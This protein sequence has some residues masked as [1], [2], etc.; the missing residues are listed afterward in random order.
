MHR[1]P[2]AIPQLARRRRPPA[3][4]AA[5]TGDRLAGLT[6]GE[7]GLSALAGPLA[8]LGASALAGLAALGALPVAAGAITP[9]TP[10][11]T[12]LGAVRLA[13]PAPAPAAAPGHGPPSRATLLVPVRY[14]LAMKGRTAG[15]RVTLRAGGTVVGRAR[16]SARLTGGPRRQPDRR[17]QFLF[18]H[19][20]ALGPSAT[21]ALRRHGRVSVHVAAP[22]RLDADGDGR[23]EARW[24]DDATQP[25]RW[26]SAGAFR[27]LTRPGARRRAP[28]CASI[29]LQRIRPRRQATIAVPQCDV[30][31]RWSIA[32][33]PVN[34]RAE[35]TSSQVV[36]RAQV[37]RMPRTPTGRVAR[38][39]TAHAARRVP[40]ARS[41]RTRPQQRRALVYRAPA[42]RAG[43][44]TLT[45][46]A[47][48]PGTDDQALVP[49]DLVVTPTPA[50]APVVRALGDS[51][52]AGFGYYGDGST[53]SLLDLP[54][55]RP[56][57]TAENDACSSNATNTSDDDGPVQYAPDYGLANDVA[58]PAQWAN[59]YGITNFANYAISG[60]E[61]ADWAP[62]GQFYATTQAVE[63]A[64][65]D[66]VVL[67]LGANPLLSNV[68]FGLDQMGCAIDSDLFG[69][70]T[71]CV[72]RW[73]AQVGLVQNLTAVYSE[74]LARTDAT[75]LLLQYH[76]S[77]PSSALAYS[78]VQIE[79]LGDLVNGTIASVAASFG[80]PRLQVV[81]PPRFDVGIDM[82]PLA[83][84]TYSCSELGYQVDGQSVQSS[85]TQD[86]LEILHPLSFCSGPAEGP[87]W[88]I[89]ADTGIH[90]S[91]AGHAQMASALPA[92][93]P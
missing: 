49:V 72:Q 44:D 68:L 29:P 18:V 59:R 70:Y 63:A 8:L 19:R 51:V 60:S 80:S 21:A 77:I 22:T 32:R 3:V 57:A 40:H 61:P 2:R 14:P 48:V 38:G 92:P 31:V 25:L 78:A 17:R 89:S 62:G 66:Y 47:Q 45:L 54:D 58:W 34:G 71:A 91:A 12:E 10:P 39:P 26:R 28:V 88:V 15:V 69:D 83:P 24:R 56:T 46:R 13:A 5:R 20:V 86:E 9:V 50:A 73:F 43:R 23:A 1:S 37:G 87:P 84:D 65:P 82:T 27:A 67:T 81:A 7:A 41:D 16:A 6:P 75:I 11:R 93:A 74:L 36:Y 79:Q 52:T 90:P 85:A 55:C 30:P 33:R 4:R 35:V 53:M 42:R 76:L 64:D